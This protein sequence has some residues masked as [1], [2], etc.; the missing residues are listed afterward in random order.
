MSDTI[1][2]VATAYGVGAI[3]I[4][5]VS[6]PEAKRVA[7]VVSGREDL[8]P[9]YAHLATLRNGAGETID[10]A[11]VLFFQAPFSFTGEDI[12]EFQ[13]HGGSAVAQLL[14]EELYRLGI[15]PARPGE[16][17][18]RAFLAGKMDMAQIEAMAALITTQSLEGAKLLARQ[19]KG[20]LGQT[21]AAIRDE[22]LTLIAHA[23]VLIDYAEEDLPQDLV[24]T[25]TE[26]LT[27]I[28]ARLEKALAVSR[29]REGIL[30][31]YKLAILGKPNVGKSSLLNA[32]LG[33]ERAIVSEIAGTTRDII[34][35]Q[36]RIGSH[37]VKI[38]DTA[39][40]RQT[41]D[42]IEQL[43]IERSR[44][45]ASEADVLLAMFDQSRPWDEEDDAILSLVRS[46]EKD[47][48]ILVII[49]K[50]DL[51]AVWRWHG[52]WPALTICVSEGVEGVINVLA[53][54]LDAKEVPQ[55]LFF[56]S[57]RQMEAVVR[58]VESI[59][60]AFTPLHAGELELFS[61]HLR[62]AVDAIGAITAPYETEEMLG[63]MFSEFCL[64]K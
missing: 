12:V 5:R 62:E 34:E 55:E 18:Q 16:F 39:G 53:Q 54:L 52:K 37:L 59:H 21:V 46:Y 20:E 26:K 31:G 49:N 15:R 41:D 6:G 22:L 61:Y 29:R 10:R 9:R 33:D 23:E 50:S 27:Q 7:L 8:T 19:L 64:G 56:V 38:V 57:T 45:A 25:I 28:S 60:H 4:V 14:L 42:R 47:K 30:H 1:A 32:L 35:E 2:A 3:S 48:D 51:P 40:I 13:C 58:T 17:S 43:G 44:K 36:L 24:T 11:I 63:R